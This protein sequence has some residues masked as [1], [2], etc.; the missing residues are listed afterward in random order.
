MRIAFFGTPEPAARYLEP[1][2]RAGHELVAVVTQPDRPAGRGRQ[3]RPSPV[4]QVA[5]ELGLRVMT[6]EDAA[7]PEFLDQLRAL[8]PEVG[9]VVAYGQILRTELLT[10][11]PRGFLNV[12]YSLL[13]AFRGAAPVYAALRAGLSE[14]GVTVQYMARRLDAGDIL[15]QRRVPIA[16]DDNRGT[17]TEKLTAVGIEALIEAL[18]LL[19]S[20]RA[21]RTPQDEGRA[22]YVGRVATEDCRIDWSAP[23]E[24]I[25][26]LVRACTP[27][28][29]AWCT[30]R[31]KRLKLTAVRKVQE[32]L[33][34]G[35]EP[36]TFVEI[37][38]GGGAVVLTGQG[39]I[40]LLRVQ[41]EGRREMSGD[42]FLRG[43]RLAIGDRFE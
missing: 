42:E 22:S 19:Q 6:P 27:W 40:E 14:T 25:C 16:D 23:A 30:L 33:N 21:P 37:G 9:V 12:H 5:E 17:L 32:A 2:V 41:P 3:P 1:L 28:P 31:G 35:R 18:E 26:N 20:G 8:A 11:P 36:G 15:L 7:D 24:A 4:R 38:N 34:A 13:P 43:A 10:L 39:G 29:G